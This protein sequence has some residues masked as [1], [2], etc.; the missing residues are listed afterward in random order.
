[1]ARVKNRARRHLSPPSS[2]RPANHSLKKQQPNDQAQC[3]LFS[4]LPKEIRLMIWESALGGQKLHIHG[5]AGKPIWL[6]S[7]HHYEACMDCHYLFHGGSGFP[8]SSYYADGSLLSLLRTC[9][10]V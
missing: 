7:K 9:Q 5:R 2:S 3:V 10:Q 6:V 4:K 8:P 1:M